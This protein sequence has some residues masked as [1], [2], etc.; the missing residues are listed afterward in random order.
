MSMV[1]VQRHWPKTQKL[2]VFAFWFDHNTLPILMHVIESENSVN[3]SNKIHLK[4]FGAL[5]SVCTLY[6]S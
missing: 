4:S 1:S 6:L 5:E 2:V 3:L